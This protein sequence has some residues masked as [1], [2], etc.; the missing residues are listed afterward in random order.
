[1]VGNGVTNWK[2]DATPAMVE[3]AYWY[4]LMDEDSYNNI[5]TSCNGIDIMRIPDDTKD[6]A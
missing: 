6:Q 2:Y 1:M 3:V 4:N 5:K